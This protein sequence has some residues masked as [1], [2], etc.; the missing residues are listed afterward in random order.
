MELSNFFITKNE[1]INH[2]KSIVEQLS[3]NNS[4]SIHVRRN[5]FSDQIGLTDSVKNKEKSEV[6]ST[7]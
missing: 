6:T 7:H 5:R 3:Y 4:I 2:K 1:L